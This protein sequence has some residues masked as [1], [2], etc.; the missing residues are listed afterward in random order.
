M[1]VAIIMDDGKIFQMEKNQL[2]YGRNVVC[3]DYQNLLSSC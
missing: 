3:P 2:K 1:G